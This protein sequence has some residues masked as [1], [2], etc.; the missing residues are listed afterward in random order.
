MIGAAA[1]MARRRSNGILGEE[2]QG[3]LERR[4]AEDVEGCEPAVVEGLGDRK[5]VAEAQSADE[6]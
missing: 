6:E 2:S 4:A 3:R 1:R 5:G